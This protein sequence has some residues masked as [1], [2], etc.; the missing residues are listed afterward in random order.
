MLACSLSLQIRQTCLPNLLTQLIQ[1]PLI[2]T[3]AKLYSC[4]CFALLA[5]LKKKWKGKKE[6]KRKNWQHG[7]GWPQHMS[8]RLG[9]PGQPFRMG[10]I[11]RLVSHG[12]RSTIV[13]Q[14]QPITRRA[15]P[16]EL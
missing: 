9:D 12:L 1:A 8:Q 3:L 6:K 10:W 5:Q 16:H 11:F 4:L 14:A 13:L 2:L 7:L 15:C